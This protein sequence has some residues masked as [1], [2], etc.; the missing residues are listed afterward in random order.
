MTLFTHTRPYLF[1]NLI[2]TTAILLSGAFCRGTAVLVNSE[3]NAER[4]SE[5]FLQL[6]LP[7]MEKFIP[8]SE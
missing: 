5:L 8:L 3:K 1:W 7:A 2:G 6:F 4:Q